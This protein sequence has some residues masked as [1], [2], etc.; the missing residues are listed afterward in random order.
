[1]DRALTRALTIACDRAL[2]EIAGFEWLTH[3]VDYQRFPA[4][5]LV[6]WVFTTE[7]QR[8]AAELPRLHALT[9][10]AFD[11]AGIAVSDIAAHVRLDSEERCTAQHGGDW[12][13]R[14]GTRG[15]HG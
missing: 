8:Q 13:T 1:M 10:A 15:Q 7:P 11:E 3:R 5:L 14:L 9:L 12:A 6:T 2:A 4:S